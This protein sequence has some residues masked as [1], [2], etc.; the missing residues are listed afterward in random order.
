MFLRTRDKEWKPDVAVLRSPRFICSL[1]IVGQECGTSTPSADTDRVQHV[2]QIFQQLCN[3]E[4]TDTKRKERNAET[5]QRG[6]SGDVAKLPG[7]WPRQIIVLF[8]H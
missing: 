8:A 4:T 3:S 1:G 6:N 7:A 2:L 5:R